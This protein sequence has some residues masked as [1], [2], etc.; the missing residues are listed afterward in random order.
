MASY[1]SY[2]KVVGDQFIDN[3]VTEN[4]LGTDVRH[5]L[6]T[7]WL[8]GNACRC[9]AGCCCLWTAPGCTRRVFFELWGAGGNGAGACSCNRCHHFRAAGGGRYEERTVA[10][11]AGCQYRVCAAGVYRCLSRECTGCYGCKSYVNGYNLSDFCSCGGHRAEA[12]TSWSTGCF[13]TR[14]YCGA[15][16]SGG[17]FG[18]GG[19]TQAFSTA[20][21]YC[22]C[23]PQEIHQGQAPKIAGNSHQGIRQCWIRC[24]CW[25]V[26][27]GTGG[28]S[29]M[30]TYCGSSCCGQGGTGGGGLVKMTYI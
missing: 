18:V 20:S 4:K 23:H 24:G 12:N 6:C 25:S 10:T 5:R 2:K 3:T 28:Q 30:N 26:P 8:I 15:A 14:H 17:N 29:A 19:A 21:G 7:K 9:S 1:E 11:T 22:H 16:I 27:Y 13:Y